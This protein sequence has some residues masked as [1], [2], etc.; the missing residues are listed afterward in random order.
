MV[1]SA[2]GRGSS[3]MAG[4]GVY[5]D[6]A[7]AA[8]PVWRD[9]GVWCAMPFALRSSL[10]F[11]VATLVALAIPLPAR[12]QVVEPGVRAADSLVASWVDAERVPGAVL[13]VLRDLHE[14]GDAYLRSGR[15]L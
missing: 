9:L 14:L 5:L 1:A 8:P 2:E 12:G 7:S 10:P 13:F 11:T 4:G 6:P 15:P 3:D